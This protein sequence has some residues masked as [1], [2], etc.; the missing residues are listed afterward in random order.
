[1]DYRVCRRCRLGWVECPWTV[2]AT[3]GVGVAA[4]G[5][6]VIPGEHPGVAWHTLGGHY[7]SSQRFW[8]AVGA[9]VAGGYEQRSLCPHVTAVA[10]YPADRGQ[11]DGVD[12]ADTDGRVKSTVGKEL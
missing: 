7:P 1:V 9:D 4:A 11:L 6:P 10:A 2:P 3:S 8:S 5:L 12:P